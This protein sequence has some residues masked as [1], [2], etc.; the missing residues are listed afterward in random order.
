[1]KKAIVPL[2]FLFSLSSIYAQNKA[3]S[4]EAVLKTGNSAKAFE[5]VR[6]Y[7]NLSMTQDPF[8]YF[9][10]R[11][12]KQL[13]SFC[14]YRTRRIEATSLIKF[15][16]VKEF[17]KN[18][19]DQFTAGKWNYR[20]LYSNDSLAWLAANYS[21]SLIYV[22]EMGHYMSL[23]FTQNSTETYTCEEYLANE[24]LAAFANSF[25][26]NKKM[27]LH[28]SLFLELARQ[29][30]MFTP[31]SNKTNFE[32]PVKKWCDADPMKSYMNLFGSNDK[33]FLRFYGYTQFR[34]MEH[35]LVNYSGESFAVF[36]DRKFYR[37]FNLFTG[38]ANF[39]QLKY[40]I[41]SSEI[42]KSKQIFAPWLYVSSSGVDSNSFF[43]YY[44]VNNLVTIIN[45][46]GEVFKS[47]PETE[48]VHYPDSN[49][50][51]LLKQIIITTYK[52][53]ADSV[54]YIEGWKYA[55]T[56]D[57]TKPVIVSGWEN[58]GSLH[59]LIK[60]FIWHDSIINIKYNY[61][62]LFNRG[63][64]RFSLQFFLPDSLALSDELHNEYLLA[65]TNMGFPVTIQNQLTKD[66]QQ[67]ISLYMI[68]TTENTL[69]VKLW[70]GSSKEKGFFNMYT[71]AV[72]F[73]TTAKKINIAFANPVSERIY[74]IRIG[75]TGT[76]SFELF[77]P[78]AN[79]KYPQ[80]M[81]FCGLSFVS[82]NQLY[83]LAGL[84]DLKE[85]PLTKVN[86]LL[87]KW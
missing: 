25:N 22:H 37:R 63:N 10:E 85:R 15:S 28:K 27:D 66:L 43:G 83:V 34:M 40:S 69:G 74:L 80:Q 26:G 61:Y 81:R 44:N 67:N 60:R 2:F 3:S 68:D 78:N 57:E 46:N 76:E 24:C 77:N 41:L 62:T 35:A 23:R 4:F 50:E 29:T 17:W 86:K 47:F 6:N 13:I 75:D 72:Y 49:N 65:G 59:Y 31:E 32:I 56:V 12:I 48:M 18:Y 19:S 58:N 8:L 84:P 38:K 1:M 64:E 51:R 42:I 73:D 14:D 11:G 30:A 45:S 55:D 39:K 33:E 70:N 16:Q 54:H 21:I 82:A 71:P 5:F 79:I 52:R 20:S 53:Q 87:I 36:L 7:F 9:K